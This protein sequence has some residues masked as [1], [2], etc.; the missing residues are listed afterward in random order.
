MEKDRKM[1][2]SRNGTENVKLWKKIKQQTKSLTI[3]LYKKKFK[4]TPS[5]KDGDEERNRQVKN[6]I[7]MKEKY[8][9]RHVKAK[10]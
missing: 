1:E 3:K 9:S 8:I 4:T 6:M 5:S 2:N 10:K 7:K